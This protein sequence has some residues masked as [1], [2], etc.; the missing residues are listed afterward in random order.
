MKNKYK[1]T[2]EYKRTR[3]V[4]IEE[5]ILKPNPKL[6]RITQKE[7]LTIS[8]NPNQVPMRIPVDRLRIPQDTK[9][10]KRKHATK[11]KPLKQYQ[12]HPYRVKPNVKGLFINIIL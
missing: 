2:I 5:V 1:V 6:K 12:K 9:S 3:E 11:P 8:L 7:I 10:W 4:K